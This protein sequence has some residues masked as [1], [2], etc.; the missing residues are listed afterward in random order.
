MTLTRRYAANVIINFLSLRDFSSD[1]FN[2]DVN[3]L[4]A[5]ENNRSHIKSLINRVG[6]FVISIFYDL[7]FLFSM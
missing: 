1:F 2:G 6:S 5:L 3:F 7:L 4:F